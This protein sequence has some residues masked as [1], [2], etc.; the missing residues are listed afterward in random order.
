[1]YREQ[2]YYEKLKNL[3]KAKDLLELDCRF[4]IVTK[5]KMEATF[6]RVDY[7][8]SIISNCEKIVGD[9]LGE[10]LPIHT[11][12]YDLLRKD[13]GLDRNDFLIK[14]ATSYILLGC[15]LDKIIDSNGNNK[16]NCIEFIKNFSIGEYINHDNE[17]VLYCI[18]NNIDSAFM[19]DLCQLDE[20]D[21]IIRVYSNRAYS[22]ELFTATHTILSQNIEIEQVSDKADKFAMVGIFLAL[23]DLEDKF[24]D[25]VLCAEKI[26]TIYMR[27]DD[28]VDFYQDIRQEQLSSLVYNS[29]SEELQINKMIDRV[30]SE[31]PRYVKEV[32]DSFEII[33]NYVSKET[34]DYLRYIVWNWLGELEGLVLNE[35]SNN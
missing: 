27:V 33:S 28:M 14:S 21:K 6:T 16:D 1:M 30:I 17:N 10:L 13:F 15:V 25:L 34:L 5:A 4:A 32:I 3:F 26:G 23:L 22:S 11:R 2:E 29:T 19:C 20:M 12:L 18:W 8:K 7:D 9:R 31:L 24:D 35:N